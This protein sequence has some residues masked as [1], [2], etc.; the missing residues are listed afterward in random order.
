MGYPVYNATYDDSNSL[1]RVR[2]SW[3]FAHCKPRS[4]LSFEVKWELTRLESEMF[5]ALRF[6]Q[7]QFLTLVH[8]P[9]VHRFQTL[10]AFESRLNQTFICCCLIISFL[11]S[12]KATCF[13]ILATGSTSF[14]F[15]VR[16][17]AA[18]VC[19]VVIHWARFCLKYR[20]VK[21]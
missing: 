18:H 11:D 13:N 14:R 20:V 6:I 4:S 16:L 2:I 8:R 1:R 9:M 21:R 15:A 5:L 19:C 17:L 12:L 3:S 7:S 10:R